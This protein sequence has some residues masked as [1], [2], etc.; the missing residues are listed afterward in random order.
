MRHVIVRYKVKKDRVSEHEALIRAVFEELSTSRP[1][2]IHYAAYKQPDGVSFVHVARIEAKENPLDS[3]AAFKAFTK[4]I[5][6]RCDEPPQTVEL[7]VVGT[8]GIER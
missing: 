2:G 6:E 7:T 3:I 8:Y 4:A 1:A 5:G